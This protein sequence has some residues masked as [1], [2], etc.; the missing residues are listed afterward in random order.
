[1]R[2]RVGF[3]IVR[4][5]AEKSADKPRGFINAIKAKG[6]TPALIAE[7]KKKSPSKGIIRADFNHID[8]AA[9]YEKAGATCISVLTDEKY[10]A[11]KNEYLAE[12]RRKV[13]LPLI[14]KDFMLEAYQIYE[15]RALGADCI[16]LIIAC[17]EKSRALELEEIA[18]SLGMDVLIEVHDEAELE[19]ALQLK[20]KLIGINNRSLKTFEVSLDNG[21]RL[22][23][24]IPDGYIKVCESGI[25]NNADLKTMHQSGFSAFLVGESLMREEDI[26]LAVRKLLG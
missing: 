12:I 7:V 24:L 13:A 18:H 17:L 10:F 23:K 9:S 8:I 5:T 14:R 16:L 1:M 19:I 2:A 25:Y 3:K 4:E 11:G 20:S 6:T 15:S 26:E 21:K 22:A